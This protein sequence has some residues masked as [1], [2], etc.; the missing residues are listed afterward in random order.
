MIRSV[1]RPGVGTKQQTKSAKLEGSSKFRGF[2]YMT[3]ANANQVARYCSFCGKKR[4]SRHHKN[5]VGLQ[6]QTLE[7]FICSRPRC[8]EYKNTRGA[9]RFYDTVIWEFH[10]YFQSGYKSKSSNT[11]SEA[12]ISSGKSCLSE[13]F[14]LSG[15]SCF[16]RLA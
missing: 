10:H 7:D 4:S 1:L 12:E 15:E 9:S 5:Q 6:N 14:E 16:P 13:P 8:E 3:A 11:L 2:K